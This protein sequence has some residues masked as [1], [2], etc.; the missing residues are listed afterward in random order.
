MKRYLLVMALTVLAGPALAAD[1]LSLTAL[2]KYLNGLKS[3]QSPFTQ[4]NDDGSLS[5]GQLLLKRPGRMRFEYAPP[6]SAL[7]V[8]GGG[9]VVIHD[10]KS[11]Q[12][13]ETY[14]L[15]RTPLSIILARNVNLGRANM[16]VG[17]D[18]DG[19]AT[20]VTAQDPE[21]PEAGRI[22]LIFTDAPVQLRKWVIYDGQGSKT[23][24]VLGALEPG[25]SLAD[26]LFVTQQDGKASD[27]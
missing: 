6:E 22:E 15:K 20:I 27:R 26:T 24:V 18:F 5:T 23:S 3:A 7:V 11:N 14:P 17:H 10:P 21:N 19:T 8:A 1:K 13:P 25:V 4:I 2:S 16:V 9:T 12:P